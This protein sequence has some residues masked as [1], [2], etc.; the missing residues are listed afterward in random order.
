MTFINNIQTIIR[1]SNGNILN[2]YVMDN[3][4]YIRKFLYK[5]GWENPLSIVENTKHNEVDIKVD[6]ND[7]VYGIVNNIEGEI[8]YLFSDKKSIYPKKLFEYDKD[9]YLIKYPY[10]KKY[11]NTIIIAYYLQDLTNKK[12]WT[13]AF[14][15]FDGTRWSHNHIYSVKAFPI[16]NPFIIYSSNNYIDLFYFDLINSKEEV[17]IRQFSKETKSWKNPVQLTSS[18]NQKLYLNVLKDGL[19]FYHITWSEF[20]NENLIIRYLKGNFQNNDFLTNE[21]KSLS[22]PANCSFPTFIKTGKALWCIWVQMNNLY[23]CY[24]MDHGNTWSKP[25]IDKESQDSNFIRYKFY[26]NYSQDIDNFNLNNI[27]GTSY[28]VMSFLGFKNIK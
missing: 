7:L 11:E 9:K 20:I 16:I 4:L 21:V 17:F 27:F 13:I 10:I 3:S 5:T 12:D 8:L 18:N 23:S 25:I 22:M 28:P 26:S 19:D 15:F 6:N 24:S 1:K 14:H 2:C